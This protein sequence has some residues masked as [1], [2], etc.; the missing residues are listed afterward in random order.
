ME[1]SAQI[2]LVIALSQVED[3][4][5]NRTK[6]Y[7]LN[8]ILFLSVCAALCGH[9]NWMQ[10]EDFGKNK[11]DFLQKY[12][13]YENGTPSHDTI[14]RVMDGICPEAF[15]CVFL[16]WANDF[17]P[18]SDQIGIDGKTI[19]GSAQK[20]T[21]K[22]ALH[23][24]NAFATDTG[25][26]VAQ[27]KTEDKSNEITAIP[28]LLDAL[29]IEGRVVTLDA[30]GTQTRIAEKILS[31]GGEYILALKGNHENLF[32]EAAKLP[33]RARPIECFE[34]PL[35]KDHGRIE[36]RTCS[37]FDANLLT[38]A[39]VFSGVRRLVRI[40]AERTPIVNSKVLENQTS[41][42]WYISSAAFSAE[43][44]CRRIRAHWGIENRLHWILDVAFREDHSQVKSK[45]AAQNFA[46]INKFSLNLLKK[47]DLKKSVER[48]MKI[49]AISRQYMNKLLQN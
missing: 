9:R 33:E 37:V 8:E 22:T 19:R 10:V 20:S 21:G 31:K 24:V 44:F 5:V 49:A 30:M 14:R 27:V 46:L 38:H 28:P 45:T 26:C 29:E 48:K 42:R 1:T 47:D 12:L 7:P 25:I 35:Q 36:R 16:Q 43:E 13:P 3:F 39:E 18:P 6:F 17:M 23:L 34:E 15:E 40:E 32:K 2:S 41:T 4:R 11:I